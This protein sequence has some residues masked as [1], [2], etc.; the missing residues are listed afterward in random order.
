MGERD[1]VQG[2]FLKEPVRCV[3]FDFVVFHVVDQFDD[4]VEGCCAC[5]FQLFGFHCF[6]DVLDDVAE[7]GAGIHGALEGPV[8]VG[9]QLCLAERAANFR[10]L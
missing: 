6:P 9:F 10:V 1:L 3:G 2:V 7:E 8:G 5:A 4:I